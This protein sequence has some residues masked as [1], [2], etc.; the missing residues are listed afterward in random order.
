MFINNLSLA[1]LITQNSFND[2]DKVNSAKEL[3][4]KSFPKYERRDWEEILQYEQNNKIFN[5]FTINIEQ[6]FCGI[7]SVW[8]FYEFIYIEHFAIKNDYRN[9]GIGSKI[10]ELLKKQYNLPIVLE[11]EPPENRIAKKRIN[12]YTRNGFS[13]LNDKYIQP[14]YSKDLPAC[15]MKIMTTNADISFQKIKNVLYKEV[16][17]Q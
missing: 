14:P 7:V 4:E 2:F 9:N 17:K 10:L 1:K 3:Y 12:F 16:Y 15:E 6:N 8:H 13:T 5:F 11:V